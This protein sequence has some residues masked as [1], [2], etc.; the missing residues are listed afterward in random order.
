MTVSISTLLNSKD[1]FSFDLTNSNSYIQ[2][3]T[4][5]ME[6]IVDP[7]AVACF[8][9]R[10]AKPVEWDS[11]ASKETQAKVTQEDLDLALEIR[12]HYSK[13]I[14]L[15]K[16]LGQPMSKFRDALNTFIHQEDMMRVDEDFS[17]L[18][19]KLPSFY[20]YDLEFDK[21]KYGAKEPVVSGP[22]F[23]TSVLLT[24]IARLEQR[25]R[26]DKAYEYWLKDPF[27]FRYMIPVS[28]SN[29]LDHLYKTIFD[30][31]VPL[32]YNTQV[33]VKSRNDLK[34]YMLARWEVEQ[35]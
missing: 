9:D 3:R 5:M 31:K 34:Y 18:I 33:G 16:L 13:R 24:P 10:S 14:M 12:D 15:W 19:R 6:F 27:E 4:R 25:T 7:I 29:T 23:K 21:M 22:T 35:K 11:I 1:L 2:K 28:S 26:G 30:K 32:M 20:R 8:L 17:G